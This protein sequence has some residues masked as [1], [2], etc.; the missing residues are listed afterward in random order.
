MELCKEYQ[1]KRI[2]LLAV[3]VAASLLGALALATASASATVLCKRATALNNCG[4]E[5]TWPKETAIKATLAPG[6]EAKMG[7]NS[8][9]E[10]LTCNKSEIE[11][12]TKNA[13]SLGEKIED[14]MTKLTFGECKQRV[15]VTGLFQGWIEWT[16]GGNGKFSS[17]SRFRLY[18]EN[19]NY[20]TCEFQLFGP[21]T[22]TGGT[23]ATI[24]YKNANLYLASGQENCPTKIQY[25]ATYNVTSP[26]PLYVQNS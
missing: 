24:K 13:G 17:W 22:L 25:T 21:A 5:Y 14:Q 26:T 16:E 20:N 1:M 9:G 11:V 3:V 8:L 4:Y 15:D 18:G 23:S 19:V 10:W 12:V 6:T 2:P 7:W